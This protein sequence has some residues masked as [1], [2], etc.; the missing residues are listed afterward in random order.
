MKPEELNVN[1]I[2]SY[3]ALLRSLSPH[4]KLELIALLSKSIKASK[5]EKDTSWES[6][7]GSWEL[8][9]TSDEFIAELKADRH[10]NRKSPDL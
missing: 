10:F 4:Y 9:Q 8:D 7:F 6:L 5:T 3:F 1:L 2:D